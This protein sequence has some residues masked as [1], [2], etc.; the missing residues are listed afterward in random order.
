MCRNKKENQETAT[1]WGKGRGN[2]SLHEMK[3][4]QLCPTLCDPM[5]YTVHG[6]FQARILEWVAFLFS[7]VPSQP[8]DQTQVSHIADGLFT[9]WATLVCMAAINPN[10]SSRA[11][12][13]NIAAALLM[14]PTMC[15]HHTHA[16]SY[17]SG[18]LL[19]LITK[20]NI[21]LF[22]SLLYILQLM[23]MSVCILF[24]V[25]HLNHNLKALHLRDD[26]FSL[27]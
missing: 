22:H 26:L 12:L 21:I 17:T 9:S 11:K 10:H 6:I 19:N 20:V 7:R 8:R 16:D 27:S 14:L 25:F 18:M 4:I 24:W 23:K 3:V 13:P 1:S 5:E 15:S 2:F